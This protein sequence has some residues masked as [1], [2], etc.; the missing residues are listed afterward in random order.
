M[1]LDEPTASLDAIA[2]KEV[3]DRIAELSGG[4]LVIF[5]SHRL[6]SATIA[7]KIMVID[8]GEL[9]ECGTHTELMAQEGAYYNLFTTQAERY[10]AAQGAPSGLPTP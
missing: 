6:S 3:F 4:R 8:A 2:E 5:V 9:I 7:D 10:Q 1:I